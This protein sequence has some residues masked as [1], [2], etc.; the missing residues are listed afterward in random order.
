MNIS[1]YLCLR[2]YNKIFDFFRMGWMICYRKVHLISIHNLVYF[3][4]MFLVGGVFTTFGNA[5][6]GLLNVSTLIVNIWILILFVIKFY[7]V[8][9]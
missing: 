5:A 6:V 8:C 7:T 9:Q 2:F 4:D 3:I 1:F